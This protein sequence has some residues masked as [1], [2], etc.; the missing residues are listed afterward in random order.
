MVFFPL[1]STLFVEI[2]KL[3]ILPA[4]CLYFGLP[5]LYF[6]FKNPAIIRKSLIFSFA[7]SFTALFV[8][9]Y[10]AYLDNVWYVPNSV[11]RFL[12]DGIPIEDG[13]WMILW[14]YFV[15]IVWEYFLDKGR[16]KNP[17]SKNTKYLFL[18]LGS[19]LFLFFIFLN[20]APQYLY[21]P[22]F[23]LKLGIFFEIIPLVFVLGKYPKLIPKIIML[24]F[25]FLL[26]AFLVER[27]GLKF[28]HWY[29]PGEHYL[30]ITKLI[31]KRLPFDEILFW[32]CLGASAVICWY[33]FFLD[34][35]K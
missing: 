25:Y 3:S 17:F 10:A 12:S 19:L 31:G 18:V 15:V 34:D 2:F 28:G 13:I 6:S 7:F 29:Y 24:A 23:F 21:Q 27:S 9:D 1:A 30:G 20:L 8:L 32:W 33:E 4:T 22:Y 35:K 16:N 26:T 5:A 14:V 11:F